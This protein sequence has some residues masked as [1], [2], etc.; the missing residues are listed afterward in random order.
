VLGSGGILVYD[1]AGSVINTESESWRSRVEIGVAPHQIGQHPLLLA[2][3]QLAK[4]GAKPKT[5]RTTREYNAFDAYAYT[6]RP[7]WLFNHLKESAI[8]IKHSMRWTSMQTA[9]T[10]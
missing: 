3:G 9:K 2:A 5:E 8:W 10:S 4:G 1:L 7:V 6:R